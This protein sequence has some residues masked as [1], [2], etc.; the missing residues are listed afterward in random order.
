MPTGEWLHIAVT[1]DV[2]AKEAKI[3]L[4]GE[5]NGTVP[6]SGQGVPVSSGSIYFGGL[7]G[8]QYFDGYIDEVSVYKTALTTAEIREIYNKGALGKCK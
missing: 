6:T 3:Y 5:V 7:P 8:Q 2:D 1:Y 4:N